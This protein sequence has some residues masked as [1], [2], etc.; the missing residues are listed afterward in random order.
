M[1][2]LRQSLYGFLLL[3][4]VFIIFCNEVFSQVTPSYK[5][6]KT[7]SFFLARKKGFW[8]RIVQSV[9]R[10]P[11]NNQNA[12]PAE[13]NINEFLHFKGKII[14]QIIL[15]D[16]GFGKSVTDTNY[17]FNNYLT[18]AAN[19]LH[20]PTYK[21]VVKDNLF[22]IEGD[23]LNPYIMAENVRYLRSLSYLQDARIEI[24]NCNVKA[25]SVDVRVYYKDVFPLGVVGEVAANEIFTSITDNNLLGTGQQLSINYLYDLNRKPRNG[26]GLEYMKRNVLGSFLNAAIGFQNISNAYSDGKKNETYMYVRADLPLVSAYYTWTGGCEIAKHFNKNSFYTDSLFESNYKY[27]YTNFDMWAGYNLNGLHLLKE[28]A[29]RKVKHFVALRVTDYHFNNVPEIYKSNYNAIYATTRSVLGSY[30]LFKQEYYHTGYIYGFGRNEDVPEGYNISFFGGWSEKDG[31]QRPYSAINFEGNYFN[32]KKDYFDYSIKLGGYHRNGKL[33]DVSAL[34]NLESFTRLRKLGVRW[35]NRMF[36]SGSIAHQFNRFLENPL[37]L[38]SIYGLPQFNADS[39]TLSTTRLTVNCE[40]VF[41][42]KWKFAGFKFA[43]FMFTNFTALKTDANVDGSNVDGYLSTGLGVR[44]RN[45]SLV[46]GTIE[47]RMSYYPRTTG[48]MK[49]FNITIISDLRYK[50]NSQYITRP[51]FVSIN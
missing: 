14:H 37:T 42:N 23:T 40:S 16:I 35:Y 9:Y 21:S 33:E 7:D 36:L 22:F 13:K 38:N 28:N 12:I 44:T 47:L 20:H 50:Y 11:A 3:N 1:H 32:K 25:K 19:F 31:Y 26:V 43:P 48:V 39:S 17:S 2:S 41:F 10:N 4:V 27:A 6:N 45:E 29:E 49:P 18:K 30:T 5:A 34:V 15:R 8:G 24:S 46:F 51:D